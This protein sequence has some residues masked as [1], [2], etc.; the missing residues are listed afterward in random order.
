MTKAV[1]NG[2]V[3]AQSDDIVLVESFSYFPMASVVEG[4]VREST[5]AASS[6]CHWKGHACYCD[7]LADGD[8]NVGAAWRYLSP[9]VEAGVVA[10][11]IAFWKGVEIVDPPAVA[12]LTDPGGPIGARTGWEAL[13]WLIVNTSGSTLNMAEI[14]ERTAIARA[15]LLAAWSHPNVQ[16]YAGRYR[17]TC[18]LDRV[19]TM[20]RAS[21]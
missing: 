5:E 14:T 1:W 2:T 11:R 20:T 9:Y 6:Y 12:S 4:R 16:Q 13:C 21:R 10:D 3:I 7:V 19:A 8:V 18:A 17:W 15:D